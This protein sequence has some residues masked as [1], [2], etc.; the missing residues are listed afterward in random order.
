M[1]FEIGSFPL[2]VRERREVALMNDELGVL[3]FSE[4]GGGGRGRGM[5][6][7]DTWVIRRRVSRLGMGVEM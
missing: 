7:E 2:R 6:E 1:R 3:T 4:E 5:G